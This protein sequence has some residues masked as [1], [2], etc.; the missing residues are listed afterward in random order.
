MRIELTDLT[1]HSNVEEGNEDGS[2]LGISDGIEL[3]SLDGIDDGV[4]DGSELGSLDGIDEG[5]EDGSELGTSKGIELAKFVLTLK[6]CPSCRQFFALTTNW[7][8]FFVCNE[9]MFGARSTLMRSL[10]TI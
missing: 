5:N 1:I 10:P 8:V 4:L 7:T 9:Y 6:A 2:E 3:G